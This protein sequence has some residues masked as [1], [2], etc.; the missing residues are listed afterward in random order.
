MWNKAPIGKE[1]RKV[2]IENVDGSV[3]FLKNRFRPVWQ[4]SAHR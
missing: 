4:F 1:T 3:Q 2:G